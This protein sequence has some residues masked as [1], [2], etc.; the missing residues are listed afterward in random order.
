MLPL[1]WV[2]IWSLVW[3]LRS[4]KAT[5][6]GKT[7][8]LIMSLFKKPSVTPYYPHPLYLSWRRERLPTPVFWPGKFHGLY[9]L[10]GCEESDMTEWL[11][12]TCAYKN[13]TL[14][15]RGGSGCHACFNTGIHHSSWKYLLPLLLF[16]S[17]EIALSTYDWSH[18]MFL[19]LSCPLLDGK[20]LGVKGH[21]LNHLYFT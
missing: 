15:T 18:S 7:T 3:E 13:F 20:F 14:S 6:S 8:V 5:W 21:I 1:Q 19:C 11:H 4:Q 2:C 16:Y 17:S 9:T 12:F 10:W